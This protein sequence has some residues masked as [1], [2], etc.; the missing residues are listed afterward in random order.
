MSQYQTGIQAVPDPNSLQAH[1]AALLSKEIRQ[2]NACVKHDEMSGDAAVRT[3]AAGSLGPGLATPP[4][5]VRRIGIIGA[6]A[7]GIAMHFLDMD[8]PVTVFDSRRE[9]TA[10][11]IAIA[12]SAFDKLVI[13]GQL[14]PDQH[15]RRMGLLTGAAN[16]HHLK[17]CDLILATL[18]SEMHV[19]EKLFRHLDEL[20]GHRTVLVT[21]HTPAQI[22]QLARA[23]RRPADVLG[24]RF[25]DPAG[26][27]SSFD[28]VR[29]R[30]TSD[31]AFATVDALVKNIRQATSPF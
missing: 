24:M 3:A 29:A 8:M 27:F 11:A 5:P 4:R 22:A 25:P 20:L 10:Q 6:G 18:A 23:T 19:A 7:I 30:E 28:I 31:E 16:F 9:S 12:R 21:N 26:P 14:A 15:D 17:D 2:E 13:A 1:R